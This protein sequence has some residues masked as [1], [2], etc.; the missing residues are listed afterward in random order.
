[1]AAV[2]GAAIPACGREP[3][4]LIS[5]PGGGRRL[6][7]PTNAAAVDVAAAVISGTCFMVDSSGQLNG[8]QRSGYA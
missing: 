4:N 8:P 2:R 5:P 7:P 6:F 3:S 1:M